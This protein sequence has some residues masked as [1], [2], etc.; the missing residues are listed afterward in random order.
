MSKKLILCLRTTEGS[1]WLMGHLI[2]QDGPS[3]ACLLAGTLPPE[4]A[5]YLEKSLGL[6][7]EK[8]HCPLAEAG[9]P[10]EIRVPGTDTVEKQGTLF[11]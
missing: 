1:P 7:V 3:R 2:L 9:G 11:G 10:Q 5:A 6:P 8:D 4:A